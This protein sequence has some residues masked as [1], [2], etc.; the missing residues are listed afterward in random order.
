MGKIVKCFARCY[1]EKENR[2]FLSEQLWTGNKIKHR[3]SISITG[4]Y[5]RDAPGA[6]LVS[7][8]GYWTNPKSVF[9]TLRTSTHKEVG[10][11]RKM[12]TPGPV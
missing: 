4:C 1:S 3:V 7:S 2:S 11:L 8:K 10:Y 5:G 6:D 12:Y 9:G